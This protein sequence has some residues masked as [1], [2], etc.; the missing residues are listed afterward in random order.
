[1]LTVGHRGAK[2]YAP[3]NTLASFQKAIEMGVDAVEL[4]VRETRDGE[5]V[6]MHDADI[7]RTT[8]GKGLVSDL[9]LEEIKSFSADDQKVP[10]FG[11]AMDFL[12]GKVKLLIELKETGYEEQVLSEVQKRGMDK[13]VVIISFRE[14][15]IK[16]IRDKNST[17]ETGLIYSKH[18]N[19]IKAALD[20]KANYLLPF[21]R[22]THTANVQKAHQKGL[23]VIV[24]NINTREEAAEYAKKGVDG[25]ASDKP[26][27]LKMLNA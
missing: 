18:S 10:T 17:I 16:K 8:N 26:D 15:A 6:V 7:K 20:L 19:P 2:A 14:D 1:V 27:I 13:K 22:F 11:E 21:Y 12:N 5:L 23:K 9:S 4:D 25:I 3:E 24:W